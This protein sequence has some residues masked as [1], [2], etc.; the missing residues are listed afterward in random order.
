[1]QCRTYFWNNSDLQLCG[2]F[3]AVV[4]SWATHLEA[5]VIPYAPDANTL[6]LWHF[7]EVTTPS[8]NALAG[9]INLGV[10]ANGATLGN[11]SFA[12]FGNC[13]VTADGGQSGIS[14]SDKDALLSAV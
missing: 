7:D 3:A 1:M 5:A 10:L 12:G 13:L 8:T 6:Q 4:L 11:A 14:T 9:G 2:L